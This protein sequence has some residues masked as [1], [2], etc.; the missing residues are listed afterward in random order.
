MR[1]EGAAPPRSHASVEVGARRLLTLASAMVFLEVAFYA[2]IA[3]LLPDYVDELH[4]GKAAAG[5]L[6]GSYAAATV[7]FALPAGYVT[8]RVGARLTVIVGLL[9]LGCSSVAFGLVDQILLLDGARFLQGC[10]GALIWAGALGWLLSTASEESRGSVVGTALGTSVAGALVGPALG[11]LAATL[12]TEVVFGAVMVVSLALAY[13]AWRLPGAAPQAPQAR[14][15]IVEA[16]TSRPVLE[17]SLFVGV[18]S[19]MFG[20]IEVLVPLRI[21]SLGGG[22]ALIAAGFIAGAAVQTVLSPLAGRASDR[23]G[24]RLP[25]RIGIGICAI[26]MVALALA[27]SLGAT[28][29]ALLIACLGAGICLAPAMV[30]ITDVTDAANLHQGFA[31]SLSNMSWA[32]GQVIGGI[33]GGAIAAAA[34]FAAPTLAISAIL[35]LGGF[36]A[37]RIPGRVTVS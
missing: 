7:I 10:A 36:Y 34:G 1:T 12:G 14:R 11:A 18:P 21:D 26:S 4:L 3:P 33:G 37:V 24:R 19:V 32:T 28:L 16:L 22:H 20:A 30:L 25:Y 35:V 31:A 13:A 5:I 29:G 27:G 2:A 6:S 15:E 8:S 9:L 17:A 23:V